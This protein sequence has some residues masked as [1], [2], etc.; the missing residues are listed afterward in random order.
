MNQIF[1]RTPLQWGRMVTLLLLLAG[2]ILIAQESKKW[3][4]VPR[5]APFANRGGI[6]F[7]ERVVN[8]VPQF[9]QSDPKWKNDLIGST[10]STLGA[11]GC[12]VTCAAMALKA[13]G[14]ETDP[15]RLNERLSRFGG[16]TERGWI[17]WE[18]ACYSAFDRVEKAFEDVG[19]HEVIDR[20]LRNGQTPI[21]KI[22]TSEGTSHFV[23]IVGKEK[24]RYLIRD[25]ST[26]LAGAT[27][28]LDE[29][30]SSDILGVR[31]YRARLMSGKER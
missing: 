18:K 29:H 12:A 8:D 16:Y 30:Y 26:R 10:T 23:V 25:P 1:P 27:G 13:L 3:S 5:Y 17:Y 21:I 9:F 31:I 11:E 28:Y 19:N 24:D 22:Q 4:Q 7:R 20:A 15:G 6:L 2:A 14:M